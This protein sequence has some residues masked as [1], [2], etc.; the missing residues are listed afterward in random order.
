MSCSRTQ[1][2]D[3]CGDLDSESDALP[4][5][6]RATITLIGLRDLLASE[7]RYTP[8]D[9][10]TMD[11]EGRADGQ[12]EREREREREKERERERERERAY[13]NFC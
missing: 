11:G 10:P 6:H 3:P 12:R 5:D 7:E 9:R 13:M 4:L 8:I 2:R 1:H